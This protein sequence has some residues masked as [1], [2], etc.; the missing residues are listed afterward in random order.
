M[1][2]CSEL[3]EKEQRSISAAPIFPQWF[4]KNGLRVLKVDCKRNFK[5]K[6]CDTWT[7]SISYVK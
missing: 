2:P 7:S 6:G 1:P 4:Y 5:Y 3:T